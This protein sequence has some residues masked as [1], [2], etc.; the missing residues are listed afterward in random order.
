M[1]QADTPRP[2]GNTSQETTQVTYRMTTANQGGIALV[3]GAGPESDLVKKRVAEAAGAGCGGVDDP[4]QR[5]LLTDMAREGQRTD[6]RALA[7]MNLGIA[8]AD[9]G[10]AGGSLGGPV[11]ACQHRR[12]ITTSGGCSPLLPRAWA[13]TSDWRPP[14][15]GGTAARSY[16]VRS[17]CRSLA[18]GLSGD[19]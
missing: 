11:R 17:H 14:L 15:S 16:I 18:A 8:E 4:A 7:L 1:S 10:T 2:I 9:T 19:N 6:V 5:R 12:F 3:I 13:A